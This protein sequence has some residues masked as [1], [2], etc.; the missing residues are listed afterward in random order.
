D[1]YKRQIVFHGNTNALIPLYAIGVFISFTLS[2]FGMFKRWITRRE[3]HWIHKAVINGIGALITAI[4]VV[5]IGVTKFHKGA[6]IVII[7]IPILVVAMLKIKQ[8]Y[9]AVAKQLRLEPEEMAEADIDNA[10]YRNRV[11]VP[12]ESINRASIRAL[13]YAETI[14]D[15]VVAFHVSIDQESEKKFMQKY[16]LLH[17]KIP[18]CIE[19]SPYRKVVDPLL[20]LIESEKYN[21]KKGDMITVILPEFE[22]KHYWQRFLHN[23]FGRYISR[24]LLRYKH[25]VVATMPLQLK[26]DGL[27]FKS[28]S[29]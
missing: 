27:L 17:T 13:K 28:K 20:N 21:Y 24:R 18:L 26:D 19:Y 3:D 6:W 2:Q 25:I 7:V 8:H 12:I 23:G 11:I 29:E 15:Q 9:L 1:V 5:I 14:S 16:E 4:V 22:V 10:T